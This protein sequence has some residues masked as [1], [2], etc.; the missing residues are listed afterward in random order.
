M[1]HDE[2]YSLLPS[3]ALG[4]LEDT[5]ELEAH[6][7]VCPLCAAELAR[8]L[9]TTAVLAEAVEPVA[10]PAS[11]RARVLAHNALRLVPR[12]EQMRELP[13]AQRAPG[14]RE[15]TIVRL[16]TH[17][18]VW[19]RWLATAAAIFLL[20]IGF[21]AG[22]L[23]QRQQFQS[24]QAELGID[25]QGLVLLTSTETANARLAPVPPL[26]GDAHGHWF[27]RAGVSTQ[28]LVVETMPLPPTGEAYWG[29][30]QRKD[31]TWIAAGRF[32]LDRTGYARIILTGS[33]GADVKTIEVTTQAEETTAPTGMIVL[34]GPS[35]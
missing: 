24:T 30:L 21:G 23:I 2:A 3:Y 27:H 20:G 9:E 11:L 18:L 6:L 8:Y 1:T 29:W 28:V 12:E 19:S 35:S 10:P 16:A 7:R 34:Q 32:S 15:T 22:S 17:R 33:D 5:D 14:V 31:G 13:P 25:Q 4:A 26:G